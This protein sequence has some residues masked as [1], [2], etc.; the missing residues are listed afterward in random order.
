MAGQILLYAGWAAVGI[1]FRLFSS[2][3]LRVIMKKLLLL[4]AIFVATVV[5]AQ[6]AGGLAPDFTL[7]DLN[8]NWH[9]LYTY[10]DQGKTVFIEV[11]AAWCHPCWNFHSQ[12][13]F[14]TLYQEHGP[15]GW[16]GVNTN[17]TDDVVVLFIEGEPFNTSS[18]LYGLNG[19][20]SA[21][22]TRGNWVAGTPFPIIDT[23]ASTTTAFLDDWGISSY[24]TLLMVCRDR[25]VAEFP[26]L[27]AAMFYSALYNCPAYPPSSTV[28]AKYI[29]YKDKAFF[30]CTP[31]PQL[32]FQNYSTANLTAAHLKI[33]NNSTLVYTHNWTGNLAPYQIADVA[34]PAFTTGAYAGYRY[35]VEALGDTY[36]ANNKSP[37]SLF[38]IYAPANAAA[39]P[40]LFDF[41]ATPLMP[42][43]MQSNSTYAG[44]YW[45]ENGMPMLIGSNGQP[46]R[47][48][49]QRFYRQGYNVV[50]EFVVG[51]YNLQMPSGVA[52]EFDLA[53]AQYDGTE[54]DSLVFEVS[55][56]CGLTWMAVWTQHGATMATT[57][58]VDNFTEFVPQS[59]NQWRQEMVSLS[60]YK[61][62]HTL[63]RIRGFSDR[64]NNAY[65][66]NIRITPS[67]DIAKEPINTVSMLLFPNPAAAQLSVHLETLKAADVTL[68]ITD[69]TGRMMYE[70]QQMLPAGGG[71]LSLSTTALADGLYLLTVWQ[72]NHRLRQQFSV[73]HSDGR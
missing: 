22:E 27:S 39:I 10:L 15:A 14:H 71:T 68:V 43:K 67:T 41:E 11:S 70:T 49:R 38:W 19:S 51:N 1:V 64:G 59:G 50:T 47:A 16:P 29:A 32:R 65:I 46:T 35:E 31:D 25:Q 9:N 66:D 20:G 53:Y 42:Y 36:P 26:Q 34:V 63:I 44:L 5:K 73:L 57:A 40:V 58:P 69:M 28:D 37:D 45:M 72:G 4:I 21:Q 48:I 8:G 7:R 54:Q 18:Q 62:P 17:T 33:Y 52:L 6:P 30:Y 12:H 56:D 13:I 60:A 55:T 61:T 3:L 23:N 24:P 2:V